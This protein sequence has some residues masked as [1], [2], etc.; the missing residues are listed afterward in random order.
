MHARP[1]TAIL[2]DGTST[3]VEEVSAP[4][5]RVSARTS[6]EDQYPGVRLVALIPGSHASGTLTYDS[7]PRAGS[8]ERYVDPFERALENDPVD[9]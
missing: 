4:L 8:T 3:R 5:D 7:P 6:V 1:Y 9:W 2:S